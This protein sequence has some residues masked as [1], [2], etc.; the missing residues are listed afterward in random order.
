MGAPYIVGLLL[1]HAMTDLDQI[2]S[3]LRF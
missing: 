1:S 3:R 2:T